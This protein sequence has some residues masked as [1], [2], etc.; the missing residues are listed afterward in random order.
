MKQQRSKTEKVRKRC[1]VCERDIHRINFGNRLRTDRHLLETGVR[2]N[3]RICEFFIESKG[4]QS[5]V[6]SDSHTEK[7]TRTL[8]KKQ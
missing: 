3:C 1:N 6:H 5:S 7:R 8:K 2:K 4:Y